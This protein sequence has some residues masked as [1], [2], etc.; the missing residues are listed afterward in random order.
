M[1]FKAL[2]G[3]LFHDLRQ[4]SAMQQ[5]PIRRGT[6]FVVQT[7]RLAGAAES[8]SA[9]SKVAASRRDATAL[10]RHI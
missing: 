10:N 9:R 5:K 1:E 3:F 4:N 7:M 8:F 2:I 6:T